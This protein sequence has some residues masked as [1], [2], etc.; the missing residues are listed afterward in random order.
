MTPDVQQTFAAELT[1][2]YE[3]DLTEIAEG[4][5]PTFTPTSTPLP[6]A[7]PTLT[8][9]PNLREVARA[10][11][12]A[13]AT[14]TATLWTATVTPNLTE[15]LEAELTALHDRD[16][17]LTATLWTNTPTHTP[18]MTVPPIIRATAT[19]VEV[20][21]NTPQPTT[22]TLV[23]CPDAPPSRLY[24]GVEGYVLADDTRLV[25]VRRG[26]G[27]RSEIR[28][29]MR[30]GET[31]T[32][33]EG[34]ECADGYA[35]YLVNYGGGGLEGWIAEGDDANYFVAPVEADEVITEDD[36]Q[37]DCRVLIE[38]DFEDDTPSGDWFTSTTDRY[39]VDVFNGSYNLQVNF[40]RDLGVGDPQGE[41]APALWGSLRGM[42][43]RNASAEAIITS[44]IFNG[45]VEAR[46]GLWVRYQS[47]TEFLAFM[48]RGDGAYRIARYTD[49]QYEDLVGW[50][51]TSAIVIGD[52][53][54]NTVRV[55][56]ERD[57]YDFFING[58]YIDTVY[59]DTWRRGRIAFWGASKQT[60]VTFALDYFRVC[61]L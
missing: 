53:A 45:A 31:F 3:Q 18:S 56:M 2:L 38:D 19:V 5:T 26:A 34:P 57:Q 55:D 47:E 11:R 25:N 44:S 42:E 14:Q 24:P 16:L 33:M 13:I 60:P 43:F 12:D 49:S 30:I 27:T 51:R 23:D 52:G 9:T 15:T 4:W 8:P 17:T 22:V 48:I 46:T 6:S 39:T 20:A 58:R 59:D 7:T 35:W 54:T 10:T 36:L 1:A 37:P 21:S 28:D 40:L 61:E 50:T 29:Q 41:E 32:V